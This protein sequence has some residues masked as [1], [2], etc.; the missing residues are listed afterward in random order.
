VSFLDSFHFFKNTHSF[1][2]EGL[3]FKNSKKLNSYLFNDACNSFCASLKKK[4]L[5]FLDSVVGDYE[6]D[7]TLTSAIEFFLN[8]D[9]IER[10]TPALT[11]ENNA[12]ADLL[13]FFLTDFLIDEH[14]E[15]VLLLFYNFN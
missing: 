10:L 14:I 2:L 15:N 4:T 13:S 11:Y 3:L 7:T 9:V 12:L 1:R 6:D 5:F 8:N